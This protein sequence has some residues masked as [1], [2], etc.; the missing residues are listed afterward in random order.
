MTS[1]PASLWDDCADRYSA[2]SQ[3]VTGTH[4]RFVL[5][6]ALSLLDAGDPTSIGL[7]ANQ[8]TYQR[9]KLVIADVACGAGAVS[10]TA[11][12]LPQVKSVHASDYSK[13]MCEI[14]LKEHKM[15]EQH[16]SSDASLPK[17]CPVSTVVSDACALSGWNDAAMDV[18]ICSFA[19]MMLPS[20]EKCLSE[21]LRVTRPG[22]LVAFT[23]WCGPQ[24][25]QFHNFLT[26]SFKAAQQKP[27]STAAASQEHSNDT[28]AAAPAS[29]APASKGE[30]KTFA[31][32]IKMPL[33][34]VSSIA[35]LLQPFVATPD[36]PTHCTVELIQAHSE[37]TRV[38]YG[39][40]DFWKSMLGIAP[41][42]NKNFSPADHKR[43]VDWLANIVGAQSKFQLTATSLVTIL[44]KL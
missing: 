35:E 21:M 22:G 6:T 8:S 4:A 34:T 20:A 9:Q 43:A 1:M 12:L 13:S 29:A 27:G 5:D 11:A 3:H 24:Q 16:A 36:A 33:S 32:M 31:D 39:A 44:R 25:S 26:G 40:N 23:T 15:L 42:G 7:A 10:L 37:P 28:A 38:F 2:G 19:M 30:F 41:M 18:T 17:P 14:V